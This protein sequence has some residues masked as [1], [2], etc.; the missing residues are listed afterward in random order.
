MKETRRWCA[1]FSTE[2]LA[3]GRGSPISLSQWILEIA[4]HCPLAFDL[5]LSLAGI[6]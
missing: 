5:P 2:S 1:I 6:K 3:L 4:R